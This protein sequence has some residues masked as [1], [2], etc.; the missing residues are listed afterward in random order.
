MSFYNLLIKIRTV[1]WLFPA[2]I[3]VSCSGSSKSQSESAEALTDVLIHEVSFGD[4]E[5]LGE[6][7][8]SKPGKLQV[9][10]SGRVLVFD[11]HKI[12]IFGPGGEPFRIVGR[13]GEGPG[14]FTSSDFSITISE[15]GFLTVHGS[16]YMQIFSPEYEFVSR[17]SIRYEPSYISLISGA[18]LRPDRPYY[19]E[20]FSQEE[21]LYVL[22]VYEDGADPDSGMLAES[23][24]VIFD[25]SRSVYE[26]VSYEKDQ[27]GLNYLGVLMF[28]PELGAFYFDTLPEKRLIYTYSGYDTLMVDHK[29]YYVLHIYNLNSDLSSDIHIEYEPVSMTEYPVEKWKIDIDNPSISRRAQR[30]SQEMVSEITRRCR[31]AGN[32]PPI[33]GILNDGDIVFAFTWTEV[34]TLGV[35]TD[36]IDTESGRRTTQAYFPFIPNVVRDGCAYRLIDFRAEDEFPHVDKY[37]INPLVYEANT[38]AKGK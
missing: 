12:K 27:G 31:E 13:S 5:S 38:R 11:E 15:T 22:D 35:L 10:A 29:Q 26:I 20:S 34:D 32:Y 4:D 19:I 3:M 23:V 25:N 21:Q 33:K 28:I 30:I 8:L 36:I 7:L 2:L 37:R 17:Q 1:S 24:R 16:P 18:N 14:E 9:D 6:F